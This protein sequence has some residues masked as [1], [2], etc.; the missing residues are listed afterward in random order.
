MFSLLS[1]AV[2]AQSVSIQLDGGSFKVTNWT[3]PRVAP[4]KGWSSIFAVYAGAG[5][6][7]AMVGSYVVESGALVFR[8]S[9]PLAPGMH[10][11][12]VFRPPAGGGPVERVFDLPARDMSRRT[13]VERI[14]PSGDVWP[15]NQL[16]LYIY[17]SAPMSR[18]EGDR[19]IHFFDDRGNEIRG[20]FLPGEEL[21][22]PNFQRLTMTFDPGRIK[23]GL[24]SNEAMGSPITE[25][26]R[27][28]MSIDADWPDARGVPMVEGFSRAF[29][30][31]PHERI[32]PDP[33]QWRIT[34]PKAG[35]GEAVV[36]DFPKPM[37]FALLQKMLQVSDGHAAVS[38]VME[39]DRQE[40]R[41][42]L[43]PKSAW[44]AGS[45]QLIVDSRLEDLAGNH[46]GQAF[47][48][49]LSAPLREQSTP[50]TI[51]LPFMV[52]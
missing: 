26:K 32:P 21:W 34:A 48:T 27:Y 31:G 49:D 47:D 19:R 30:G 37:N 11:R 8:P 7:P 20:M 39:V 1:T 51:A 9:Y 15:G 35:T 44:K 23:R 43:T 2:L 28:R 45:Y 41:W 52:R 14:Y 17:F 29:R 38:G 4:A 6:M 13:R 50:K 12:A 18:G 40:T 22:D 25:G 42:R 5:Q 33:K 36:V 16:R 24:T 3:A 10:Y 46:I